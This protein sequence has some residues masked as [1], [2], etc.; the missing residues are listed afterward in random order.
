MYYV[1]TEN[2]EYN[3]TSSYATA[4]EAKRFDAQEITSGEL[5][6]MSDGITSLI[7]EY[8]DDLTDYGRIRTHVV[9]KFNHSDGKFL[10][11]VKMDEDSNWT[12]TGVRFK[13]CGDANKA[14]KSGIYKT[15]AEM[16][17]V[18]EGPNCY[19]ELEDLD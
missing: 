14:I 11:L 17:I 19:S 4:D 7:I 16:L 18:E 2:Q 15:C 10:L 1:N 5:H 9:N 8:Q 3:I 12:F 13:S 6:L